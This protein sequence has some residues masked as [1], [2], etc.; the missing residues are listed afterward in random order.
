MEVA[1]KQIL[2]NQRDRERAAILEMSSREVIDIATRDSE[3]ERIDKR[4]EG[5]YMRE[6]KVFEGSVSTWRDSP[7]LI[8]H[9][10]QQKRRASAF[11]KLKRPVRK[12]K[13]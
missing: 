5:A 6:Q 9:Q 2:E 8:M 3:L 13:R 4:F 7:N 11:G 12:K 1:V 10:L